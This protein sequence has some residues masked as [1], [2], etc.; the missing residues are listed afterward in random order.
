MK[1]HARSLTCHKDS[2]LLSQNNIPGTKNTYGIFCVIMI[3]LG[4]ILETVTTFKL[5]CKD[6]QKSIENS[7]WVKGDNTWVKCT[8]V[9]F[10][11]G[12]YTCGG[13]G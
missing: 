1:I 13:K 5:T 2:P 11:C 4:N 9:L 6:N 12:C 7:T 3:V 10:S 8:T